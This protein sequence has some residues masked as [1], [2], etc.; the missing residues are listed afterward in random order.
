[1]RSK[2][3]IFFL[4]P[5]FLCAQAYAFEKPYI[6]GKGRYLTPPERTALFQQLEE[7]AGPEFKTKYYKELGMCLTQYLSYLPQP[8]EMNVVEFIS[9]EPVVYTQP[10]PGKTLSYLITINAKEYPTAEALKERSS[11]SERYY[12]IYVISGFFLLFDRDKNSG[13]FSFIR[14]GAAE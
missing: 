9:T 2:F 14:A 1:M 5:L 13:E 7:T 3:F 10:H 11:G 6:M 8:I 4:V 12:D